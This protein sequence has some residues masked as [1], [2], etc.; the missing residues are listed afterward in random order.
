VLKP[1]QYVGTP[2]GAPPA[3]PPGAG[4]AYNL[5]VTSYEALRSDIG[6]LGRMPWNFCVLDE[7]HLQGGQDTP[8]CCSEAD[9]GAAPTHPHRDAHPGEAPAVWPVVCLPW[10]FCVLDEGHLIKGALTRLG[11]ETQCDGHSAELQYL[12]L[13]LFLALLLRLLCR[14]TCWSSGLSSTS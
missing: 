1:F 7:G 3:A 6:S 2:L 10:N 8:G 9:Q 12:G 4:G 13:H 5:V 11:A 14:T